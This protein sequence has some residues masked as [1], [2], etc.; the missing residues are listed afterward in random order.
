MATPRLMTL[1]VQAPSSRAAS[2]EPVLGLDP[3][4]AENRPLSI[5]SQG[6]TTSFEYGT[7]G[8]RLKKVNASATTWYVG[9][10]SELKVDAV[11]PSGLMTSYITSEVRRVGSATGFLLKDGLGSVRNETQT[12]GATSSWRDYGPYGMPNTQ[13]GLSA[14]NGRGY[15]NERFDPETGLQYLHARYYDPHL[16]RFLSPDTWDPTRAGVDINRYACSGNDPV[17]GLDRNGHSYRSDTVGGAPD[18]INGAWSQRDVGNYTGDQKYKRGTSPGNVTHSSNNNNPGDTGN[19][20]G[21]NVSGGADGGGATNQTDKNE[22]Q[23]HTECI[24]DVLEIKWPKGTPLGPKT[25]EY[26]LGGLGYGPEIPSD[27]SSDVVKWGK[28]TCSSTC[29]GD[30]YNFIGPGDSENYRGTIFEKGT[31]NGVEIEFPAAPGGFEID[32]NNPSF[33]D[34][35]FVDA[36]KNNYQELPFDPSKYE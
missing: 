30:A 33:E 12:S 17:N 36:L 34:A 27:S 26:N 5:T 6:S 18:N 25:P 16:G 15:I 9:N 13:S 8:E 28:Y 11:T 23:C 31:F 7:D 35:P 3:G 21:S 32:L 29:T 10:D 20:G 1:M 4:N 19:Q 2:L 24:A 22:N 14:A